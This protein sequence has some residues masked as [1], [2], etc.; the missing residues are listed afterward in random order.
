MNI[1]YVYEYLR[2]DLTPY[3]I[4][5]GKG[6]RAWSNIRT[7]PKP[8]DSN[9]I[10]IIAH[11]LSENEAFLL[12]SKLIS[13]YGRKDINTGILRNKTNGGEGTAGSFRTDETKIKM[14]NASKGKPKSFQH[15]L[16]ISKSKSGIPVSDEVRYRLAQT[17]KN[18]IYTPLSEETKRK[19]SESKRMKK[20]L[21]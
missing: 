20:Q 2:K 4:G 19:I 18:R 21:G 12:E 10:Q 14:S 1:Y 5:K 11:N 16:N 9:L 15:K 6:K 8:T 13:F 3:Y 17:S 7:I